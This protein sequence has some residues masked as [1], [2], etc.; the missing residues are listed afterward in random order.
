MVERKA[1]LLVDDDR[2]VLG[3]LAEGLIDAGYQ[4]TTADSVEQALHSAV[5][6]DFD[7]AVLDIRMPHGSGIEL[8]ARL[9]EDFAISA[10]FLTAFDDQ[11]TVDMAISEGALGYLVK[12]V[13][14]AKLIPVIEAALARAL[15]LKNL[16]NYSS[17][18]EKALSANRLVSVAIG[19]LMAELGLT[20]QEAFEHLRKVAR[21]RRHKME[22]VAE[23]VVS[24]LSSTRSKL[25]G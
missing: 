24:A 8:A 11:H 1:L 15:D 14:V 22:V 10:V 4:I 9:R 18:L 3:T 20:E 25:D 17:S 6:A 13:T 7:L 23:E 2:L 21:S 16:V 19:I 5:N 12:P